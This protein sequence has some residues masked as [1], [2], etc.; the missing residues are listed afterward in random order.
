MKFRYY[1]LAALVAVALSGLA[2]RP[3]MAHERARRGP[4]IVIVVRHGYGRQYY[5]HPYGFRRYPYYA[6]Y[7]Y[8]GRH[9]YRRPYGYHRSYR[10][11]RRHNR[12]GHRRHH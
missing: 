9:Y 5:G 4:R 10:R 1:I 2:A 3:A 7:G 11:Y 6:R 12:H 8:Y